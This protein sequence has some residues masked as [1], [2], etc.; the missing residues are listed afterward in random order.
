ML[1]KSLCSLAL[2]LPAAAHMSLWHPSMYGFSD[3]YNPVTPLVRM[4]FN[5]WWFHG[6]INDPPGE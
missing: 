3:S 5:Q 6:A 1:V 2:A 4:N